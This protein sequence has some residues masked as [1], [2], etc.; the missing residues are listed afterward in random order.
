MSNMHSFEIFVKE[1]VARV[2]EKRVLLHNISFIIIM[3]LRLLDRIF[4][5]VNGTCHSLFI[6]RN[7]LGRKCDKSSL[8]HYTVDS[9]YLKVQGTF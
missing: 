6:E 1:N 9:R 7:L 5:R 3:L 2:N 8:S 4:A